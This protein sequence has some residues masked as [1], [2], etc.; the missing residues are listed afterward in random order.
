MVEAEANPEATVEAIDSPAPAGNIT[1]YFNNWLKISN[2]SFILR[3]VSEG[4]KLQFIQN[5][6]LPNSVVSST[7]NLNKKKALVN[8]INKYL[9]SGAISEVPSSPLNILSRIFTVKKSNGSDRMIIDLSQLNKQISKVSFQMETNSKIKEILQKDDFM[10]SIDLADAFFSIPI[11]ESH[12]RFLSFEFDN[13]QY[14]FNVLPFG[15]TSSPRIFSKMLKPSIIFL[16]SQGIK[17]SFYLDDIF[18]C[19]HSQSIL[20][21]H[22]DITLKL[23]ISLGFNPNFKKSNLT[24]SQTLLHLGYI[25]NSTSMTISVPPEKVISTQLHAR[26]ILSKDP[27]MREISSF[28]GRVISHKTG[29][30]LAPLHFRHLQL[31]F[32]SF[33]KRCV[34]WDTTVSLNIPSR[35][36]VVWWSKCPISLTPVSLSSYHPDFTLHTDASTSGWGGILSSG[37]HTSGVWSTEEKKLHINILELRAVYLCV[38]SFISELKNSSLE[39]FSDNLTTVYYI[40]KIGG[41][42]SNT[43]CLLTLQLWKVLS[44][45]NIICYS[46]HIP[47]IDNTL[48]DWFSRTHGDRHDYFISVDTFNLIISS[49]P[50]KPKFDLFASRLT[51]KLDSYASILP[52]PFASKVDAFSFKWNRNLYIFP[53]LPLIARVI[54][55]IQLDQSE[56]VLLITPAWPGL[57]SIPIIISL[58]ISNPIF[59]PSSLLLGQLPTRHPFNMMAWP[60]STNAESISSYLKKC[61]PPYPPVSRS[62][63]Y[64]STNDTGDSFVNMLNQG[65]HHVLCLCP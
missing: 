32:C 53:P 13:K 31:Q 61:A 28:L 18:L 8:Q 60:I 46:S 59:I 62:L 10:A 49:I 58:L 64:L 16:R 6:I 65:G 24:P 30:A 12:K 21:N 9:S 39:I 33:L 47:G 51:F 44:D 26:H 25:W 48:A 41:T 7:N 3:I 63:H 57:A 43:L 36:D 23:L 37:S 19:S 40:N 4:Y 52:D 34:Q 35:D 22:I 2:N 38:L 55:K 1:R 45:N 54:Q 29:F 56:N 42:H 20:K 17:I 27:T 15:L 5:P 11:H 50:F 14:V